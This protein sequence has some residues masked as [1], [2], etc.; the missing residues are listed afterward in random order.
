MKSFS[1]PSTGDLNAGLLV[2]LVGIP[3]CLAYAML[4]GLPPMYGLVTAI[5]PGMIAAAAGRSAHVTVGPTNTTGLIILTSLAP[6]ADRPEL[7]LTAM[8]TLSV[9]AGLSRL[10]IVALRAERVFDF[11][12]EAVLL[13]FSTGAAIII[14]LMQ[15]DEFLGAPF[16][17]VRTVVDE[18]YRLTQIEFGIIEPAALGL[19]AA[20]LLS[21]VLGRRYLPRWPIPL[22][23]LITSI[24]LVWFAP[25]AFIDQWITLEE[26]TV[27]SDGWPQLAT[28]LPNWAMIQAL[29]VPGFAVAFIGSLELIVTLRNRQEQRYLRAELGSQGVANLAGSLVGA[30]PASTSLTRSVLLDIGG[31]TSRWAPFIAAAVL[32]PILLFGADLIRAIPQPVIAGLLVATALS[33]LKPEQIASVL[34]ANRQTRTLFIVTVTSTLV[35][36]FHEAILLGAGLGLVIFLLQSSLPQLRRYAVDQNGWLTAREHSDNGHYAI[37]ISGSLYFAAARQLP[38]RLEPLIPDDAQQ[39]TLDLNHAHQPR[40]AATQALLRF[41]ELCQHR[42]IRVDICGYPAEL[43]RIADT[44]GVRLPWCEFKIEQ[45]LA[46]ANAEEGSA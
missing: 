29:I 45:R 34:R 23:A 14:A 8:V 6:W 44:L 42:G 24:A 9:L 28:Q 27:I 4:S 46:G 35:L 12:P 7:L 1:L 43:K 25:W 32:L 11:V 5:V 17:G 38:E 20:A 30:F 19:A 36:A 26:S 10:M 3:Q 2:A 13:G 22:A 37:Q 15:L 18:I 33:M 41:C 16:N 39:L 21:V 31:A 40:I